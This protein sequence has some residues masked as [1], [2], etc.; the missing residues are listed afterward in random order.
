MKLFKIFHL[1]FIKN[2]NRILYDD[3]G[4]R[5][6]AIPLK[7]NIKTNNLLKGVIH[8]HYE[9]IKQNPI[10]LYYI[11]NYKVFSNFAKIANLW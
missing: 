4:V 2:K 10:I 9:F 6:I 5:M 1:I 7:I 11:K 3:Y 8:F